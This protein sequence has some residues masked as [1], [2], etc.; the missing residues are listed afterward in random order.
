MKLNEGFNRVHDFN[1]DCSM[2]ATL[3]SDPADAAKRKGCR[4]QEI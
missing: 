3:E 4:R 1:A 2:A